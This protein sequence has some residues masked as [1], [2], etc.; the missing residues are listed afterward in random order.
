[1][2]LTNAVAERIARR[3][4]LDGY[5]CDEADVWKVYAIGDLDGAEGLASRILNEFEEY[6]VEVP[7]P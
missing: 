7:A 1:M 3:M 6:G 5:A 2:K 4:W